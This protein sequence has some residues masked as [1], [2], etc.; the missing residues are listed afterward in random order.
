VTWGQVCDSEG[1]LEV[2][3][4]KQGYPFKVPQIDSV[5][6]MGNEKNT[7][8]VWVLW[9]AKNTLGTIRQ[10]HK[11]AIHGVDGYLARHVSR[12]QRLAHSLGKNE[13]VLKMTV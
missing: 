7:R 2:L 13:V 5:Q 9:V 4:R 6:D 12:N 11:S 8:I 3:A 10:T 1:P